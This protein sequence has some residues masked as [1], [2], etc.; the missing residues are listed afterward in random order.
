MGA[1][2]ARRAEPTRGPG[3]AAAPAV[4]RRWLCPWS[5]GSPFRRRPSST[6]GNH[7]A[8]CSP[9]TAYII[10][11]PDSRLRCAC[12]PYSVPNCWRWKRAL[13]AG[14]RVP[15][16]VRVDVRVGCVLGK[17]PGLN[18]RQHSAGKRRLVSV[19]DEARPL[20][21]EHV[22]ALTSGYGCDSVGCG[23]CPLHAACCLLHVACCMLPLARCLLHVACCTLHAACCVLHAACC[24][25]PVAR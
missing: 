7:T 25:L 18:L 12:F 21:V 22:L 4:P 5:A 24:T 10:R 14:V 16:H 3:A 1:V 20:R 13:E 15:C 6:A 2:I 11:K 19:M 8:H 17:K 23:L 9:L